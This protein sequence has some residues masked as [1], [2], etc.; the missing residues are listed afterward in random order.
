M[1]NSWLR[2][3][4]QDRIGA[5]VRLSAVVILH[6]PYKTKYSYLVIEILFF[7]QL[8][9]A[10]VTLYLILYPNY[11]HRDPHVSLPIFLTPSL[12]LATKPPSLSSASPPPHRCLSLRPPLYVPDEGYDDEL[13]QR[14]EHGERL[15]S[16]ILC[17]C[18]ARPR[19]ST[20]SARAAGVPPSFHRVPL[21][22]A[23][24]RRQ[25]P[26]TPPSLHCGRPPPS[27]V[28]HLV[29]PPPGGVGL[30][31]GCRSSGGM[32]GGGVRRWSSSLPPA[33][34]DRNEVHQVGH[35]MREDL[36]G[37]GQVGDDLDLRNP[38]DGDSKEQGAGS[39]PFLTL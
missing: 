6:I 30:E 2:H 3:W 17:G 1:L 7:I 10:H 8:F 11:Q 39:L 38:C 13:L 9:S 23:T 27:V 24:T 26:R 31:A 37:W 34:G 4:A 29:S 21:P 32:R 18:G 22:L 16:R 36:P 28:H 35:P 25:V 12:P 5:Y 14:C 20:R 15:R 33:G 19:I